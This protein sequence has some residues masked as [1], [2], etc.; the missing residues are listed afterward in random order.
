MRL[1]LS[2]SEGLPVKYT[3]LWDAEMGTNITFD[4][5]NHNALP[6]QFIYSYPEPGR[7][8]INVTAYNLHSEPETGYNGYTHNS[9]RVV[10]VEIPVEN[11]TIDFG[12]PPKMLDTNGGKSGNI[13]Q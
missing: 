3:I 7:Y 13:L 9:S 1:N 11:F 4:E 2:I 6:Q 10:T 12:D 8:V 5:L